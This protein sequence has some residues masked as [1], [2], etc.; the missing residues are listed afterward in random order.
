M[1]CFCSI[2]DPFEVGYDVAHVIKEEAQQALTREFARSYSLLATAFV[3]EE[4]HCYSSLSLSL[5]LSYPLI[6][7]LSSLTLSSLT[8]Q[9]PE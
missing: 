3:N 9:M 2:A 7:H 4:V 6:S 5:S 1:Y 8:I